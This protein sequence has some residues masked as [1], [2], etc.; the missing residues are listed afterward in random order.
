MICAG[1]AAEPMHAEA[2]GCAAAACGCL[3][4][5][6][7]YYLLILMLLSITQHTSHSDMA[8]T[9]HLLTVRWQLMVETPQVAGAL[10][11]PAFS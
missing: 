2:N 8:G 6:S 3:S 11:E 4:S 9:V 5:A 7:A 10:R 1:S